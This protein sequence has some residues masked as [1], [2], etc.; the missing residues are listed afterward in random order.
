MTGFL[1]VGDWV[2]GTSVED[3]RVFGYVEEIEDR[4]GLVAVRVLKSDHSEAV[5]QKVTSRKQR[6]KRLPFRE[7]ET[8][9]ELINL[10]DLALATRDRAWFEEIAAKLHQ[11]RQNRSD[12]QKRGSAAEPPE[13]WNQY[14]IR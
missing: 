8:E 11:V 5:G 6:L 14:R 1:R 10:I 3:E 9:D 4:A 7:P 13:R 12:T 2:S